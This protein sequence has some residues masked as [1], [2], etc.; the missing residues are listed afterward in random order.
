MVA[1][2]VGLALTVPI[3]ACVTRLWRELPSLI[4]I[5]EGAER[6]RAVVAGLVRVATSKM[7]TK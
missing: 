1:L 3:A 5:A 2:L 4:S 6:K 7:T